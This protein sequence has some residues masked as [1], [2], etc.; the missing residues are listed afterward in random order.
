MPKITAEKLQEELSKNKVRP[1][2]LLTGE[3][4]YR[5]Q[6]II[7]KIRESLQPDDF[8]FYSSSA[9]KS[10]LGEVLAMA[11]TAPVFS[12]ARMLV[13]TGIEKLR[14]EP[15]AA[16]LHYVSD[17]LSTTTLVLTHDDSKKI[18]T[19]R[20]L[21]DACV[22]NGCVADFSELK[23]AELTLWVKNKLVARGLKA[24]FE[25]V[26]LLCQSVGAEL[27]AL[28]NELEKLYLYTQDRAD[29]TV[30]KED[31]LACIGFSKEENPFELSNTILACNKNKAVKLVDKLLDDGEEPVAIL[32]KMTYPILKMA[33]IKRMSEGGMTT[34][35]IVHAAGLFP[36]ESRLVGA[37]RN[38]PSQPQ[39]FQTLNRIIEADA[40][41][42]SGGGS[43]PKIVLKGILLTLFR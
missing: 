5:K 26:D 24:D 35:D 8:N 38:Y 19:E 33:R 7:Q 6:E 3:D 34:E 42:K 20:V 41:F 37:A 29:K 12:A 39:F 17:P 1:V 4:T 16:L 32:S 30:T 25:A 36:W 43:D 14:K 23:Q 28:E 11:N 13:L 2:Y 18:K 40:G 21:L 31:V 22:H 10:D 15:K 9:D 27:A